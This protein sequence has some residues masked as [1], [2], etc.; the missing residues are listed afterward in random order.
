[1]IT[2]AR[3]LLRHAIAADLTSLRPAL[4]AEVRLEQDKD[5]SYWEP[6]KR[7]LELFRR[8]EREI[9]GD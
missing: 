1:M 9:R 5:R 8:E 4:D 3:P 2:A 6:L 7:E